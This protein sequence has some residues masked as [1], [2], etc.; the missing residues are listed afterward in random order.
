MQPSLLSFGGGEFPEAGKALCASLWGCVC[1]A[2]FNLLSPLYVKAAAGNK[3]TSAKILQV[4]VVSLHLQPTWK[5]R[6]QG[7]CELL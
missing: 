1:S 6:Y 7:L 4:C 5:Q 2:T 3:S